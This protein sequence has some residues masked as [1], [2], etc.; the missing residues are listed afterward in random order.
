M[1]EAVGLAEQYPLI[2]ASLVKHYSEQIANFVQFQFFAGLRTSEAIALEWPNVDFNS[3]EVLVHEVIVYEQAQ[4]STK[5]STS[6]KVR[7]NSEA[8]AALERQKKFTFLASG[9]VFHDPLY[10]EP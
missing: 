9:K 2:L 5:T 4:D 3:G 7:L 10:N 1:A 8:M 6:R